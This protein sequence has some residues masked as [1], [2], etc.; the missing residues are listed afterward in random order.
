MTESAPA[1]QLL[2]QGLFHHRQGQLSQ[3]MDQYTQV[4]RIDPKNPEALYYVAMVACQEG[5]FQQGIELA[6]RALQVG[7]PQARVHNLIGKAQERLG[8]LTEAAKAYDAAIALDPDFAEAHGNR[9]ALVAQAGFPEEALI[10]FNRALALDPTAAPDWL[11]RGALLQEMGR[12]AEALESYDKALVLSPKEPHFLLNRANALVML[13]RL[14]EADSVYEQVIM[15]APKMHLAY[16][17]KGLAAKYRGRFDEARKLIENARKLAPNEPGPAAALAEV[18]LLTGDWRAAWPLYEARTGRPLL[19]DIPAWKGE[20]AGPYRLV[21]LS[22][23]RVADTVMFSRYA[24]LLA[25]RGYDVTLLTRSELAPLLSSLPKVERVADDAA[26]LA[27]DPRRMVQFPL[28]SMMG[29]LHLTPDTVPQQCPYLTAPEE[30]V[31]AWAEKLAGMDKKVG[32]CWQGEAG[33]VPLAEFAPLAAVRGVRLIAL[34]TQG[35]LRGTAPVPFTPANYR[36]SYPATPRACSA[37]SPAPA[38]RA[39][40]SR[41]A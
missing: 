21:L 37:A 31:K 38:P 6:Q 22:E 14:E 9:A 23:G 10:S 39:C 2:Q 19:P 12:H 29:A 34:Q 26:V 27:G 36:A 17:Q 7:E 3:A 8:A 13:G 35:V 41:A 28:Q 11:N 25:G 4:L 40:A 33:G 20:P 16:L 1:A 32:I 30:R 5:Q 15:L 18:Q 24:A